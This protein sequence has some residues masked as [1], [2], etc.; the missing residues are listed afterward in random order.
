MTTADNKQYTSSHEWITKNAD[1]SY[2][3]GITE[4]AQQLLGDIV[5]VE[6]PELGAK[7][8][9]KQECC[10]IESVKAANGVYAPAD[11]EVL[12]V[13]TSL[14]DE[15]ELVNSHCYDQG[16]LIKF[17]SNSAFTKLM[18]ADEYAQTLKD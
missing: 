13:N 1:D 4:H 3:L 9:A 8:T 6:L 11:L 18:S 17:S 7:L 15:P 10:V 16:W 12:A 14:D 2:T 5:F